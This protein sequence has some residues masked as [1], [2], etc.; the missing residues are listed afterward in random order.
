MLGSHADG[1]VGQEATSVTAVVKVKTAREIASAVSGIIETSSL[2]EGAS[3]NKGDL[4]FSIDGRQAELELE[5]L[6]QEYRLSKKEAESE[7][8]ILFAEKSERVA[9][10]ELRRAVDA[11]ARLPNAVSPSEMEKLSLLVE[12]ASAEKQKAV[13]EKSMKAMQ[14]DVRKAEYY[15]GKQKLLRHRVHSPIAGQIV[16]VLKKKGEWVSESEVVAKIVSLDKLIVEVKLKSDE[17]LASLEDREAVFLPSS[18]LKLKSDRSFDLKLL[19]VHPE[20]NPVNNLVVVW[21]ELDNS[22]RFLVPG[23]SGK[24]E[25]KGRF[26]RQFV[27]NSDE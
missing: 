5:R 6:L 20:V 17:A 26:E 12:K 10:S 7:V 22:E 1:I 27:E 24:V 11:N 9:Q 25:V 23:V 16:E 4:L 14:S 3:I 15:I 13:F 19:F 2:A 8:D 21:Y 18:K